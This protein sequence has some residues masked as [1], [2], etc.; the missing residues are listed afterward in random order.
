MSL[1]QQRI[2]VVDDLP[3]NVEILVK[4][5]LREKYCV[6]TASSGEEC[7]AKIDAFRPQ[8]VLLD[9]MMP[10]MN[11]YEVCRLL[12]GRQ[13]LGFLQVILVSGK[14]STAERIK[15]YQASADDYL[16]KPFDHDEL[17]SKVRA[18]FRLWHAQTQLERGQQQSSN[19]THARI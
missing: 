10:G 4:L 15:G 7:L 12:K 16:V 14:G 19:N 13:D 9:I 3:M 18:H 17:L 1:Q 11:G 5:L 2:L 8:L 6:E